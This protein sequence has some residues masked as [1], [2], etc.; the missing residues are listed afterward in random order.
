MGNVRFI[1]ETGT[2]HLPQ[3]STITLNELLGFKKMV[4]LK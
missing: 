1:A 2:L 3:T 4:K